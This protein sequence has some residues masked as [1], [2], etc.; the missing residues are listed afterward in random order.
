M[1]DITYLGSI[2]N[3]PGSMMSL[4][5]VM[6]SYVL[7]DGS[8]HRTT[9]VLENKA[10]PKDP[11]EERIHKKFAVFFGNRKNFSIKDYTFNASPGKRE[12]EHFEQV[13]LVFL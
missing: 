3:L 10:V 12:D 2:E 9:V 4:F 13:D 5:L 6:N 7:A 11:W 1:P 8:I